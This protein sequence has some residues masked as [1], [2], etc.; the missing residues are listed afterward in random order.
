MRNYQAIVEPREPMVAQAPPLQNQTEIMFVESIR[1]QRRKSIQNAIMLYNELQQTNVDQSDL[2]AFR[3]YIERYNGNCRTFR[4]DALET[5]AYNLIYLPVALPFRCWTFISTQQREK[6]QKNEDGIAEE[7]NTARMQFLSEHTRLTNQSNSLLKVF[8]LIFMISLVGMLVPSDL[9]RSAICVFFV[10]LVCGF[11]YIINVDVSVG[12]LR[13][14][15]IYPTGDYFSS[16]E[17]S[18]QFVRNQI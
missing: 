15:A 17:L 14:D 9:R 7:E 12:R 6:I 18:V 1:I 16:E 13:L 11:I 4:Q 2:I 5:P 3:Q 8:N 10:N